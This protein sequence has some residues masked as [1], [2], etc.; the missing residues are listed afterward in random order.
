MSTRVKVSIVLVLMSA[1]WLGILLRLGLG[2]ATTTPA[3]GILSRTFDGWATYPPLVI[4][5]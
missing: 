1:A 2:R 3:E 4:Y 5:F